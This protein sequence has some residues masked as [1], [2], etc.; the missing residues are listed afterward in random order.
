MY[1]RCLAAGGAQDAQVGCWQCQSASSM[2]GCRL[3]MHVLLILQ[4]KARCIMG[5]RLTCLLI[6]MHGVSTRK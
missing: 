5:G 6:C 4:G 2:R 1:R 3:P